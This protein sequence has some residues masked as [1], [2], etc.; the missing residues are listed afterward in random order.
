MGHEFVEDAV[1]KK[2]KKPVFAREPLGIRTGESRLGLNPAGQERRF[3]SRRSGAPPSAPEGLIYSYLF[4]G[5]FG[6]MA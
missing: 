4:A 1:I 3:E 5:D 6:Q 2:Y